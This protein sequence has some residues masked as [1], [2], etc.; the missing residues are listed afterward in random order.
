[1]QNHIPPTLY[2]LLHVPSVLPADVKQR[3]RDL[4]EGAIFYSVHEGGEGVFLVEGGLL[5]LLQ[6][7]RPFLA[8]SFPQRF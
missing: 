1:M 6:R 5:Q 4:A 2:T 3:L 8:A 7:G